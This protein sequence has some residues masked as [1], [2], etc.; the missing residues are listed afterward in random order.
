MRERFQS[1]P[2][3]MGLIPLCRCGATRISQARGSESQIDRLMWQAR[4]FNIH[5]DDAV[6]QL[7]LIKPN[8]GERR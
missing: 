4:A 8:P 7:N 6:N 2:S 3:V 5:D 1:F